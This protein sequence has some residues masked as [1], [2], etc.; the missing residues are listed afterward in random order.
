MSEAL[1]VP[2]GT[3]V[4]RIQ[5]IRPLQY[6]ELYRTTGNDVTLRVCTNV[7]DSNS[8]SNVPKPPGK[9]NQRLSQVGE[10]EFAHEEVMKLES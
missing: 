5:L 4:S 9:H 8:S 6:A 10:P 2:A 7:S 3:S 1:I